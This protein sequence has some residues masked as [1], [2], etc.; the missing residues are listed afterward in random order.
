MWTT[1]HD[2]IFH[3]TKI[4]PLSPPILAPFHPGLPAILLTDTSHLNGLGYALLQDNGH[5]PFGPVWLSFPH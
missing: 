2:E 3:C 4:A 5:G 1:D